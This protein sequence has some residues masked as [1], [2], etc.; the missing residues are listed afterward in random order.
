M[1]II[2]KPNKYYQIKRGAILLPALAV[3]LG[4]GFLQFSHMKSAKIIEAFAMPVT[5]KVVVVDAGHGGWG[6]CR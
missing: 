6:P 1:K 5:N 2:E 4:A 3:A